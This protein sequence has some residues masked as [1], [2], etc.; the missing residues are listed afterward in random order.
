MVA[1]PHVGRDTGPHTGPDPAQNR[2]IFIAG[3]HR[4]A[5]SLLADMLGQ[6]SAIA[7][8]ANAPVPEQEGAYLQGA[9]PHTA[10]HGRPGHFATDPAQH[11]TEGH[12]HNSLETRDRLWSDWKGWFD[13]ARPWLLEKSPVNLIRMRLLQ[14]LFPTSKFIV[15]LRHP[16][17]MA[18]ALQKW[19]DQSEDDLTRYGLQA[20]RQMAE[21]LPHLHSY[22]VLRY[23]DMIAA[24]D[25]CIG[26]LHAF[27][28]L[29]PEPVTHD[30]RDGNLDYDVR[31]ELVPEL[32]KGLAEWGYTPGGGTSAFDPLIDD[33]LRHVREAVAAKLS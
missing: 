2:F 25:R 8:I 24:P 31:E 29:P 1:S 20:Y 22:F 6:H 7:T 27:M 19:T 26:A 16:Q 21:D 23:E 17:M 18:A 5:T 14:A 9:I 30:L 12:P 15:I 32:Q 11:Y 3:L 28:D 33:P 13:C 4:T 10:Q